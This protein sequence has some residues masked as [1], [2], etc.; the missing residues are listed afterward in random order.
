MHVCV[1][2]NLALC[3]KGMLPTLC[4][5]TVSARLSYR[6]EYSHDDSNSDDEIDNRPDRPDSQRLFEQLA[7]SLSQQPDGVSHLKLSSSG[8]NKR[9]TRNLIQFRCAHA[10]QTCLHGAGRCLQHALCHDTYKVKGD[11]I[12]A[13][14][15]TQSAVQPAEAVPGQHYLVPAVAAASRHAAAESVH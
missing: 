4:M 3:C 8:K 15:L 5:G 7:R 1:Q 13:V 6:R 10:M 12:V 14:L 9:G 11:I 2:V